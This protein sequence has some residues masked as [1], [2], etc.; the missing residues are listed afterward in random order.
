MVAGA[1]ATDASA[2]A[3]NLEDFNV[4]HMKLFLQLL[5]AAAGPV[6]RIF[7]CAFHKIPNAQWFRGRKE[8]KKYG[9]V[10]N[11]RAHLMSHGTT[12]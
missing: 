1:A 5:P 7:T 12:F 6:R 2:P 10:L 9:K 3:T 11:L 8:P 4:S